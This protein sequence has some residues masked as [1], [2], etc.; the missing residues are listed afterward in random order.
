MR[1]AVDS[2]ETR[3]DVVSDRSQRVHPGPGTA[4]SLS[5][6]GCAGVV[7][8]P[9]PAQTCLAPHSHPLLHQDEIKTA[10]RKRWDSPPS[11][12]ST[13]KSSPSPHRPA[14]PSLSKP[15]LRGIRD[16]NTNSIS[17]GRF[18]EPELQPLLE[19]T[20]S[21]LF[22]GAPIPMAREVFF[23]NTRMGSV[24]LETQTSSLT[25]FQNNL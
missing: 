5:V 23:G 8:V 22:C 10:C 11:S 1:A 21:P 18:L 13:P 20:H 4:H 19:I 2:S 25:S 6:Y 12:T 17:S 24:R 9:S 16:G 7:G 14:A 3:L 15:H